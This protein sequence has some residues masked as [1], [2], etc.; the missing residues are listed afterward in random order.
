MLNLAQAGS[1][2]C[3]VSFVLAFS[4]G[5]ADAGLSANCVAADGSTT[6]LLLLIKKKKKQNDGGQSELSE[7]TIQSAGGGGGCKG[8]FKYVCEKMKS[9]KKCC[10]CVADKNAKPEQ[11]PSQAGQGGENQDNVLWGDYQQTKPQQPPAQGGQGGE[12]KNGTLLLPYCEEKGGQ[13]VC[14]PQP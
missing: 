4:G 14:T 6:S 5:V 9:G 8:G 13:L 1:V 12:K 10:G 2:L 11:A 3:V 7:C